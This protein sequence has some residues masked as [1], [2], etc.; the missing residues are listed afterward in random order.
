MAF[1]VRPRVKHIWR[2]LTLSGSKHVEQRLIR[3]ID[4]GFVY[5]DNFAVNHA[6][7]WADV[8]R[9]CWYEPPYGPLGSVPYWLIHTSSG[10]LE[11]DEWWEGAD[12]LLELFVEN[13]GGFKV[14][15]KASEYD[16]QLPEG[17]LC[18][19]PVG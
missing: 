16:E 8:Q 13:L 1:N 17:H 5:R 6:L 9:V 2:S 4:G 3:K 11:I 12:T 15:P 14:P 10:V 19:Q 18:W 7:R